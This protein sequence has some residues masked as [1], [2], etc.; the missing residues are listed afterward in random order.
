MENTDL[1]D[2]GCGMADTSSGNSAGGKEAPELWDDRTRTLLGDE[3]VDRLAAARVLVVGV[4]GV[5]GYAAEMLARAGVGHLTL[6]DADDVAP[7]NINRQLIALHST[8]GQPKTELFGHRFRDINPAVRVDGRREFLTP[9]MVD[10]LLDEGFDYVIDAID[11]VAPK[12]SLIAGCMRRGVRVI[13]SMGAGGRVDPS[14]VEYADLWDTVE[15]GLARAVRQRLK[16]LG[17]RRRLQVVSSREAPHRHAVIDLDLRNKRSSYGTLA[18]IPAIFG[19]MLAARVINH[20]A[21]VE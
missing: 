15:D 18:T 9:E 11:T 12:V 2:I 4:G 7:S 20:I 1:T 6:I 8:I 21:G 17:L 10:T 19:I 13:S 16:R 14:K 5:G 3:G